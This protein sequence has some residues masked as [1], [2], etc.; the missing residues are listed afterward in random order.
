VQRRLG[1]RAGEASVDVRPRGR[2]D[3]DLGGR[4]RHV[5]GPVGDQMQQ[6]AP[7]ASP[8]IADARGGQL[9]MLVEELPQRR[10]VARS[11]RRGDPA[12]QRRIGPQP[13]RIRRRI[14]LRAVV[15]RLAA[16]RLVSGL[17]G[18]ARAH[19]PSIPPT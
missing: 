16:G 2:E 11:D 8:G 19:R 1:V 9:R 13:Q 6:R 18:V 14:A 5:P 7:L 17:L 12:R 3:R 10:G 4:L 15:L